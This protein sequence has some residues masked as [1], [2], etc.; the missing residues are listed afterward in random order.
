MEHFFGR[1]F[2]ARGVTEGIYHDF[3]KI[4]TEARERI[5]EEYDGGFEHDLELGRHKIY[6]WKPHEKE[7]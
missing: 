1:S 5:E 6:L 7:D 2:K 4:A 3:L